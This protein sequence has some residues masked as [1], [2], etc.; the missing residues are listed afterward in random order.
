MKLFLILLLSLTLIS[1]GKNNNSPQEAVPDYLSHTEKLR[2]ECQQD[3][4][5]FEDLTQICICDTSQLSNF[6]EQKTVCSEFNSTPT[7]SEKIVKQT[8]IFFKN[9]KAIDA[10]KT[11]LCQE[12]YWAADD[13]SFVCLSNK[14]K[15]AKSTIVGSVDRNS[16][17]EE[18]GDGTKTLSQSIESFA[19]ES[20][21]AYFSTINE[22]LE[23]IKKDLSDV[24]TRY[25]QEIQN[26]QERIANEK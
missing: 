3:G 6:K 19:K 4:M 11:F 2:Q 16:E 1:C 25:K 26:L 18:L 8:Q 22:S 14:I 15:I 23:T 7:K 12:G 24:E 9:E 17:L 21:G 20:S 10:L 13:S 5:Y